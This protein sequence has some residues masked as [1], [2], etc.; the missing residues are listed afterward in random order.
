MKES[1]ALLRVGM[2][3]AN[4]REKVTKKAGLFGLWNFWGEWTKMAGRGGE[5]GDGVS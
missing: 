1:W 4:D 3:S 2:L 5:K